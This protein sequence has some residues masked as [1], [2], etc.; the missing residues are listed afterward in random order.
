M[1]KIIIKHMIHLQDRDNFLTGITCDM[2]DVGFIDSKSMSP[3]SVSSE[4]MPGLTNLPDETQ[5][6][7]R[8]TSPVTITNPY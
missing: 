7:S 5:S 2:D 8:S 4:N 3:H 6:R 1:V